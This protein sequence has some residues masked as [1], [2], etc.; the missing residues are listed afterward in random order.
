MNKEENQYL[1]DQIHALL[2]VVEKEFLQEEKLM[3]V[4]I[5]KELCKSGIPFEFTISPAGRIKICLLDFDG[6]NLWHSSS[7]DY[8]KI[9][10]EFLKAILKF[11]PHSKFAIK[12]NNQK[13][14][15]YLFGKEE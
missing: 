13:W 14:F 6:N 15:N 5:F 7:D 10:R 2:A 4:D 3:F 1:I 8:D 11:C 9:M 12:L